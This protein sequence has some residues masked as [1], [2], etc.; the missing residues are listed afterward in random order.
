M[1]DGYRCPSCDSEN[2][3]SVQSTGTDHV[4]LECQKCR[5][6]YEVKYEPDGEARLVSV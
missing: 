3:F 2:L 4:L 1:A 6:A 5:R